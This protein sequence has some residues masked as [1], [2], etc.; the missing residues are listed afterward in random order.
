MR[1]CLGQDRNP[2]QVGVTGGGRALPAAGC[3][4]PAVQWVGAV[5]PRSHRHRGGVPFSWPRRIRGE[6]SEEDAPAQPGVGAPPG[7]VT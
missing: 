5:R 7:P 3:G 2:Q 1:T 4:G 6:A